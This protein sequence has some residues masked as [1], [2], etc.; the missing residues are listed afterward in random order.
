MEEAFIYYL[1]TA[2]VL[3]MGIIIGDF[4]SEGKK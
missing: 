2:F 1:C 4:T 3:I